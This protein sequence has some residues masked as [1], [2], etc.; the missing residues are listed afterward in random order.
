MVLINI[1]NLK[2]KYGQKKDGVEQGGNHL[3][4]L[5][6][7]KILSNAIIN[8]FEFNNFQDYY[9][10][11]DF[12]K[13]TDNFTI[14]FGG[15][16]SVGISTVQSQLDKYYD[17]LLVIWI[18]AHTDINTFETSIS[19]NYHGMPV[20]PLLGLMN[21]WW[22]SSIHHHKL[23]P[24][25]LL[26]IGVRDID[27]AEMEFL[28]KLNI[29]YYKHFSNDVIEFINKHDTNNIHISLD[30]D[31]LDPNIMP[32]TGTISYNGLNIESVNE[33]INT[34]LLK[35]KSID[36]VEFNPLIGTKEEQE[37]TLENCKL[38]IDNLFNFL[39]Q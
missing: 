39:E 4:N 22:E 36:I 37:R 38:I 9:T 7:S 15:D 28:N 24:K 2:C 35:L 20:S 18:D 31:G 26:Y 14:N 5:I 12:I 16:H 11:Y 30:I 29:K 6:D 1:N 27:E 10:V 23:K 17:D 19:K 32:S 34:S 8:E 13:Q 25:N 33:I 3:I 21:H